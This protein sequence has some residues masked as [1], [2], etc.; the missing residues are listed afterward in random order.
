MNVCGLETGSSGQCTLMRERA[1]AIGCAPSMLTSLSPGH[2]ERG[3]AIDV[4]Y[5]GYEG[6]PVQTV[7]SLDGLRV[8]DYSQFQGPVAP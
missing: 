8:A 4:A 5:A 7:A 3:L 1:H 6:D 2:R